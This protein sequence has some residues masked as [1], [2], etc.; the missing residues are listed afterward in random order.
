MYSVATT[1]TTSETLFGRLKLIGHAT[2]SLCGTKFDF[3]S[4][5]Q[6]PLSLGNNNVPATNDGR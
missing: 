4:V 1:T 5:I 2:E 6:P 3:D